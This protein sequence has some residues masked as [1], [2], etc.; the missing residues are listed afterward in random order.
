MPSITCV[1]IDIHR[2]EDKGIPSTEGKLQWLISVGSYVIPWES[3]VNS[4]HLRFF[5]SEF[6]ADSKKIGCH[7]FKSP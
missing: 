7:F 4:C 3:R 5:C 1:G 2:L 6:Y